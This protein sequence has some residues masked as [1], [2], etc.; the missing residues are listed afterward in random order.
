MRRLVLVA[1]GI[2]VAILVLRR[3]APKRYV[4]VEFDDASSIRLESDPEAR[5]LL[6]DAYAILD[7]T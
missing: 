1:V 3:R 2:A 7:A 5:D 4:D 6:D